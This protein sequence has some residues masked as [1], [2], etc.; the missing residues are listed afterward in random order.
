MQRLKAAA[1]KKTQRCIQLKKM[2]LCVRRKHP[3]PCKMSLTV[4]TGQKLK[5]SSQ[6]LTLKGGKQDL[7]GP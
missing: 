7:N 1:S 4:S 5:P 6:G 3:L 2:A